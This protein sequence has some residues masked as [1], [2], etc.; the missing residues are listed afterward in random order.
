MMLG[1]LIGAF[2][3]SWLSD[4]GHQQ[5]H[6][7]TVV[8]VSSLGCAFTLIL[9]SLS[10]TVLKIGL[11]FTLWSYSAEILNNFLCIIPGL[12]FPKS[13]VKRAFTLLSMSWSVYP[14]MMPMMFAVHGSWRFA[15]WGTLGVPFLAVCWY[16]WRNF[17]ELTNVDTKEENTK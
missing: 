1:H 6:V 4:Y 12:F 9:S 3:S 13:M 17:E 11:L 10:S 2:S 16:M 7:L 15:L 14:M 8:F 5:R